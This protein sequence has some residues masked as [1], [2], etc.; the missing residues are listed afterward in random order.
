MMWGTNPLFQGFSTNPSYM[1]N[2]YGN[3]YISPSELSAIVGT[4]LGEYKI[5]LKSV[6][7]SYCKN[8]K[9]E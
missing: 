9:A 7:Y 8:G 6:G 4:S 2:P 5:S 1:H 3:Y